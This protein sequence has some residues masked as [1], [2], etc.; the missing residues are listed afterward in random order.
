GNDAA[1]P[2]DPAEAVDP[3]GAV[4]TIENGAVAVRDGKILAVGKTPSITDRFSPKAA[5]TVLDATGRAVIPGFVDPHTHALFAGDRSD[6]FAAKLRGA[7]Y[8]DILAGGGGIHRTVEAVRSASDETLRENLRAE[9]DVMLAHGTTT[10]EV[11]TGYGL[12]VETERRMLA[13]IEAVD[14]T[15]P[16]DVVPTFLGAH[17]VPREMDREAYVDAVIE[18]QLPAVAEQGVAEFV[19]VFCDEGAFTV[20]EARRILEAGRDHGLTPKIHAEEFARL[21]GAQLAA[22]LGAASADHLLEATPEDAEALSAAGVTAVLLPGTAFAL[23]TDYADPDMFQDAGA[24]V[25]LATDLNPNCYAQSMQ[26]AVALG[27]AGMRMTPEGALVAATRDAAR[28][29]DRHDGRG[30]ARPGTPADLLVLDAP[31]HVYVPYNVGINVVE[32]VIKDGR[33]V[34]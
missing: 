5:E 9:L 6:E 22:D 16:I 25:A 11:K 31:S 13:A 33:I 20:T 23:D 14:E 18:E 19:D 4:R 32:T 8:Q 12:D 27:C 10:A 17:A 34:H 15:H 3:S 2:V 26:F 30:T 29:V 1:D 28:A 7:T 21:G 24:R